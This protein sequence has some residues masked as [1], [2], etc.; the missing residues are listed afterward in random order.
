MVKNII[1]RLNKRYFFRV[2]TIFF[3]A[4]SVMLAFLIR[5]KLAPNLLD[6][7]SLIFF[8]IN[9]LIIT[10]LFGLIEGF[11]ALI[12]GSLLSYYFFVPP[13]ESWGMPD[14]YHLT[15]FFT[16][17]II[18]SFFILLIVWIKEGMMEIWSHH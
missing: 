2:Q 14:T 18:A 3:V 4:T 15:S 8:I 5:L 6:N 12:S 7:L 1:S 13:F 10:H 17:F 11:A 9:S 16:K